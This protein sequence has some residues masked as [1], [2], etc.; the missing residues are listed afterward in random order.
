MRAYGKYE[1]CDSYLMC[2][3]GGGRG[4]CGGTETGEGFTDRCG[5]FHGLG[6]MCGDMYGAGRSDG[7]GFGSAQGIRESNRE[8]D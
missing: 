4:Q 1:C 3:N 8:Y 6:L 7:S 2:D 5:S